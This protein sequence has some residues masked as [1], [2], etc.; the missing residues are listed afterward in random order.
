MSVKSGLDADPAARTAALEDQDRDT[1][2]ASWGPSD[3][4]TGVFSKPQRALRSR[5]N[6][7]GHRNGIFRDRGFPPEDKFAVILDR[8]DFEDEAV[9]AFY[10]MKD[11]PEWQYH[12]RLATCAPGSCEDFVPLECA[13]LIAYETF[14]LI[15]NGAKDDK[16]RKALRSMFSDNGFLGYSFE[17]DA[18]ML[19]KEPLEAA[20]CV[21][22]GFV[23]SFPLIPEEAES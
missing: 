6:P 11:G 18:L 9:D 19:L 2:A 8:N 12:H 5:R 22:N 15:H 4:V 17:P 16:V 20:T 3:F 10:K 14:R 13:D 7:G 23:V 21:E 1:K